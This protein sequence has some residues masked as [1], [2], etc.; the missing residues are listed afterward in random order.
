[1]KLTLEELDARLDNLAANAAQMVGGS[2]EPLR[3]ALD[4]AAAELSEGAGPSDIDHVW[5]RLQC[6]Q[7]D[8]GLIPG[9][10]EPCNGGE[11]LAEDDGVSR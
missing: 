11:N 1:M 10:D 5:S 3:D 4:R 7:R 2:G 6:I 9:D 8:V